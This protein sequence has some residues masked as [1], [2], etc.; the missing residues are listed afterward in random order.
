[1][2][3]SEVLLQNQERKE[4]EEEKAINRHQGNANQNHDNGYPPDWLQ[5]KRQT[6]NVAKNVEKLEPSY[7][8]GGNGADTLEKTVAIPQKV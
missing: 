2:N 8:A 1:M 4:N 7:T 6:I 3:A 5:S